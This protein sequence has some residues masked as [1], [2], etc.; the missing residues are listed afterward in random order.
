MTSVSSVVSFWSWLFGQIRWQSSLALR[1][2]PLKGWRDGDGGKSGTS[3]FRCS[4][5][6]DNFASFNEVRRTFPPRP[7]RSEDE[8]RRTISVVNGLLDRSSLNQDEEDYL[9]FLALLI[10]D[11][12]DSSYEHPE[13]T[14]VD[15]L[16]HLMEAVAR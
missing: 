8:H 16:R 10:A 4:G 1:R 11:Y 13:F 9:D 15:R 3:I 14:A 6:Q 12:E 7:I 2:R 5:F